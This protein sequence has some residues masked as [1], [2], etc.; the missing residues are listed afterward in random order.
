MAGG[1]AFAHPHPRQWAGQQRQRLVLEQ[2]VRTAPLSF[3][4][5]Q[6]RELAAVADLV[7][8]QA[9]RRI[10]ATA[11]FPDGTSFLAKVSALSY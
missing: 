1:G 4:F 7:A 8:R 6:L 5:Q 9:D 11:S 2:E 10:V 3:G